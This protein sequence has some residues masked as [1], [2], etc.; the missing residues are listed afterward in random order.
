LQ[1]RHDD[2][3]ARNAELLAI[4]SSS[5]EDHRKAAARF[6]LR[7]PLLSDLE[8]I[9]MRAY[10][11]LHPGALPGADFPI[12][13]PAVFLVDGSGT[14]RDRRLTDNWRVRVRGEELLS[15]LDQTRR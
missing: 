7:F 2:L 11:V 4:S 13:R 15:M 14:I 12:A 9:A 3:T 6:G 5:V 8:G 1:A 10:G